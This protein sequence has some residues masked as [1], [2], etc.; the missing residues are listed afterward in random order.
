MS[1]YRGE[2]P[3]VVPEEAEAARQKRGPAALWMATLPIKL[4]RLQGCEGPTREPGLS[5]APLNLGDA[6]TGF[7]TQSNLLNVAGRLGPDWPAVALHLGL[8]YR[9]LQR[10]RHEFRSVLSLSSCWPP[11]GGW[12][13]FRPGEAG[14]GQMG[15]KGRFW[16]PLP[17]GARPPC[18]EGEQG[19]GCGGWSWRAPL[20]APLSPQ[21]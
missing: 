11:P 21:G 17:Q 15:R 6:E 7:L 5:L 14:A 3:E 20:T 1:F 16:P 8:P 18:W 4:P 12:L 19:P 10:I 13:R 2:V 9:E